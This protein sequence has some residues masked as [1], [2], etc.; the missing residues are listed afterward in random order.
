MNRRNLHKL[1]IENRRERDKNRRKREIIDAA[2]KVFL[3][4][5]YL[6]ATMDDVAFQA[7]IAKITAYRYFRTKDSLCYAVIVPVIDGLTALFEAVEKKLVQG[8]YQSGVQLV[9]DFFDALVRFYLISP[10]TFRLIQFFQQSGA[11]W[12]LDEELRS[13]LNQKGKRNARIG[14]KILRTAADRGLLKEV[15]IAELH[16]VLYGSFIGIIQYSEIKSHKT[17]IASDAGAIEEQLIRRV[18]LLE[19]MTVESMVA[20]KE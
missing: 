9:R 19:R 5:G 1:A 8:E 11:V 16:D 2:R 12:N 10:D 7:G 14:R 18:R 17:G 20:G 15:D 4:K 6:N 3:A 13:S